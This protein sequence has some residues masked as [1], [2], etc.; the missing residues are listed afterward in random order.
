MRSSP[1]RCTHVKDKVSV[2]QALLLFQTSNFLSSDATVRAI[3]SISHSSVVS[4]ARKAGFFDVNAEH[5]S[6]S[7]DYTPEVALQRL[8]AENSELAFAFSFLPS[9]LPSCSDEEKIWRLWCEYEGRRRTAFLLFLMDTV[10]SLDAGVPI[11]VKIEEVRHLPLPAPD[12]IWRASDAKSFRTALE[13]YEAPSLDRAMSELLKDDEGEAE[14]D[15]D[16]KK[17]D[18][19]AANSRSAA[20]ASLPTILTGQHGPFS[21]LMA[22]LPILRGIVHLLQD[23]TDKPSPLQSW[24]RQP[25]GALPGQEADGVKE[26]DE[27]TEDE[28]ID[29]QVDLFKRALSRWREGWDQDPL[30]LQASSP[31][32]QAKAEAARKAEELVSQSVGG[33]AGSDSDVKA[34]AGKTPKANGG[35]AGEPNKPS[36]G[37]VPSLAAIFTSKTASGA[38][39]LCEDALPFYW[40]SHVLL[41]HATS[42][43]VS[44]SSPTNRQGGGGEGTSGNGKRERA[45]QTSSAAS[46][47][48]TGDGSSASSPS[49][50]R[51]RKNSSVA[52]APS[53][54]SAG[55]VGGAGGSGGSGGGQRRVPDFRNMLRF[56]KTFV[57]SGEGVNGTTSGGQLAFTPAAAAAVMGKEESSVD[58]ALGEGA[59]A[60]AGEQGQINGAK[61]E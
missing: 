60:G 29:A 42:Q 15:G 4:L 34:E 22:I 10:A 53:T 43:Q 30:C 21:R 1:S 5:V 8:L 19:V 45:R 28:R 54:S 37:A 14:D 52:P 41:G 12:F 3:A 26:E 35:G 7:I 33:G 17:A 27:R 2:V 56:A 32:A 59:A 61:G 51:K 38:T 58:A 44:T 36:A 40:L 48:G 47:T 11:V 6:I 55:G 49:E 9:Y 25:G 39:P 57:K 24:L 50:D 46:S 13:S 16:D 18:S 23:R 20:Q 31:V